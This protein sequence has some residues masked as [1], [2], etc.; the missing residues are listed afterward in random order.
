M[1]TSA[2]S[3][4][5]AIASYP[6]TAVSTYS[7][8]IT[9]T[10]SSAVASS[11][12]VAAGAAPTKQSDTKTAAAN[13]SA[14]VGNW[15]DPYVA[16]DQ[17]VTN[18]ELFS[19][20]YAHIF[21]KY[22]LNPTTST[23]Q[24]TSTRQ[25][26]P[27]TPEVCIDLVAVADAALHNEWGQ[28]S[29]DARTGGVGYWYGQ[30]GEHFG[31]VKID[32]I[33]DCDAP[34]PSEDV[35]SRD[36]TEAY[37]EFF[38]GIKKVRVFYITKEVMGKGADCDVTKVIQLFDAT[39]GAIKRVNE[40]ADMGNVKVLV[41]GV[42]VDVYADK[43]VILQRIKGVENEYDTLDAMHRFCDCEALFT[44]PVTFIN[45]R[46]KKLFCVGIIFS[47]CLANLSSQI[48][49]TFSRSVP[50]I[51]YYPIAIKRCKQ[52][53]V[54]LAVLKAIGVNYT[55]V[56]SDNMLLDKDGN[57]KMCDFA[58]AYLRDE[59]DWKKKWALGGFTLSAAYGNEI[60]AHQRAI[61]SRDLPRHHEFVER[62][63]LFGAAVVIYQILTG[64]L[65]YAFDNNG[66]QINVEFGAKLEPW[67][68][69]IQDLV[70]R[71]LSLELSKPRPSLDEAIVEWDKV[72]DTFTYSVPAAKK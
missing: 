1:S 8:A 18:K 63:G 58:D 45:M 40:Y 71:M 54:N 52:I 3:S 37:S 57:V 33:A 7:P 36:P 31:I 55:D 25:S 21:A 69:Q 15:W 32:K 14:A 30:K 68:K 41:N 60:L 27:L 53:V 29:R 17:Y 10:A 4:Q 50:L 56:K 42:P 70:C 12:T 6:Y 48:A 44:K 9:S 64:W 20:R 67:G 24:F 2:V 59:Y 49:S 5:A 38:K 39:F 22:S 65:P 46:D 47:E 35:S 26:T 72:S 62:R 34:N 66:V 16:V 28:D 11:A 51:S 43:N 19:K 61:N 23:L 13:P